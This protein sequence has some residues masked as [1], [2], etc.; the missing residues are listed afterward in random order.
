MRIK[1][2]HHE[3]TE[4]LDS[5]P[6][7][8][9]YGWRQAGRGVMNMVLIVLGIAV[10]I[11]IAIVLV[12]AMAMP[13]SRQNHTQSVLAIIPRTV[14]A[15]RGIRGNEPALPVPSADEAPVPSSLADT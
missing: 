2:A 9:S 10:V 11:A 12:V 6:R 5:P 14:L 4:R 13:P 15:W 3:H 7:G 8:R 1:P